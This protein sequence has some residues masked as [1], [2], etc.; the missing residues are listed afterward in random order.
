M[1][2]LNNGKQTRRPRFLLNLKLSE[3][4]NIP[5]SAGRCYVKWSL[6]DGTGTSGHI[7]TSDTDGNSSLGVNQG[8]GLSPRTHISN[9]RAKWD[10]ELEN[11][12]QVKLHV[13]KNNMLERKILKLE[14]YLE[15]LASEKF[16]IKLNVSS[17]PRPS[18]AQF[19]AHSSTIQNNDMGS[20]GYSRLLLG[21][22]SLNIADYIREDEAYTPNRYLLKNSKVNTVIILSIQM[23]L[24]RGDYNDFFVNRDP[25]NRNNSE[26][27]QSGLGG[28]LDEDSE[29]NV[30]MSSINNDSTNIST[31]NYSNSK[32]NTISMVTVSPLADQLYQKTFQLPWD[33]RAG[34]YTPKECVDDILRGG[35]GWAK[36]EKGINLIDLRNITPER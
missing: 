29:T 23:Q 15:T 10:Y 26:S 11:P 7:I 17:V 34:E 36:N 28:M 14:F 20:K 22:V 19:P 1:R 4:I 25:R 18:L 13:D 16:P 2:R 32:R 30:P 35:N 6:K 21:S 9:H 31:S 24:V 5:Q 8:H 3:L 12:V 27:F 33:Q